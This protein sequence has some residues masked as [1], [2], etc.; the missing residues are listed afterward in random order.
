M[1]RIL[2]NDRKFYPHRT[3]DEKLNITVKNYL[4]NNGQNILENNG[5]SIFENNGQN[6]IEK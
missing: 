3:W 1:K 6:I 2:L 5:Q 4:K